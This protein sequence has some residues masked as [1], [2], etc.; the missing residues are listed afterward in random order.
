MKG[1]PMLAGTACAAASAW[2][3]PA[4]TSGAPTAPLP[5]SARPRRA[6][7]SRGPSAG[8]GRQVIVFYF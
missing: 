7:P 8:R 4:A 1:L 3:T 6:R 5:T 2:R